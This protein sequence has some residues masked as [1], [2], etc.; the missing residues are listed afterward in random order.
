MSTEL[1]SVRAEVKAWERNFK[2][3][4]GREPT[5]D[6]I[7]KQPS[8]A[9][10][11]KIYKKLS[12]A[13]AVPSTSIFRPN[14]PSS[15]PPRQTSSASKPSPKPLQSSRAAETTTPLASFN[16]FS[17]QKRD[18]GKQREII[19]PDPFK[20]SSNPFATPRKP[21]VQTSQ[22][23]QSPDLFPLTQP[24]EPSSSALLPIEPP[25][26]I[27]RARKR[28]RGEP[29]SPSPKKEKRKRVL[30]P[31]N[32]RFPMMHP[33]GADAA[34]DSSDGMEDEGS[35]D[36][37]SSSFV[38]DS[39]MKP[40]ANGRAFTLL[41]EDTLRPT[42]STDLFGSDVLAMKPSRS[43]RLGNSLPSMDDD[44]FSPNSKARRPV[45]KRT[46][47]NPTSVKSQVSSTT[48]ARSK[49]V[50][51]TLAFGSETSDQASKESLS[52]S[53][54]SAKRVLPE[55]ISE[56]PMNDPDTESSSDLLVLTSQLLPPSPNPNGSYGMSGKSKSKDIRTSKATSRK[57]AKLRHSEDD[58]MESD[59][60]SSN[61]NSHQSVKLVHHS[62]GIRT[63]LPTEG[64][65]EIEDPILNY[66][67]HVQPRGKGRASVQPRNADDKENDQNEEVEGDDAGLERTQ[68]SL[69]SELRRVLVLESF[70]S[71]KHVDE[72]EN[73]VKGLLSGRRVLHYDPN[74]GGEVWGV[75]EDERDELAEHED[76]GIDEG[77]DEWEGDPIPW[78]VG[79]LSGSHYHAE[80]I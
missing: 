73:V 67:G 37:A 72:E 56:R 64:N 36:G 46:S 39:P 10:K 22:R 48:K 77:E 27:S 13:S 55:T 28:L 44:V 12:K 34:S 18:K 71:K 63:T 75:G 32:L 6:D 78:E 43:K 62:R 11:Y 50:Q 47:K 54:S 45:D 74:K 9:Q 8:V 24:V 25:S 49:L 33:P 30:S 15:T 14:D 42:S 35:V 26:G 69:P 80:E 68:G 40:A 4:N 3:E 5:V 23:Q 57:K 1:A 61:S 65:P 76:G 20:S 17:P 21:K 29:V 60:G 52:Q 58:S 2:Q 59:D 16:P 41:F 38:D 66:T 70:K 31:G 51:M 79:E 7:R 53:R 19:H